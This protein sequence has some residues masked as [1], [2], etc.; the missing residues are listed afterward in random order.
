MTQYKIR[1]GTKE[2]MEF[3]REMLYQAIYVPEGQERPSRNIIERPEIAKYLNGWGRDGDIAF[4]AIDE[5]KPVGAVWTRL[6]DDRNQ[7]YGYIN[8]HTPVLSCM[9]VSP[10]YRGDGIGTLLLSKMME[11]VRSEGYESISLSV[12]PGNP[13]RRLYERYGF[14]KVG[15]NGT[16][17]DMESKFGEN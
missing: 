7:T 4:I 1:P 12:D 5:D 6:F 16:S 10:E 11:K 8:E 3:L 9:A 13:A 14:E 15:I 2:D 17:W